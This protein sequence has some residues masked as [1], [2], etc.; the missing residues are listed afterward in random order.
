[1][2]EAF[3]TAIVERL[4]AFDVPLEA[5][6]VWRPE[7]KRFGVVLAPAIDRVGE[8]WRLGA[9]LIDREAHLF[10]T[11]KV[12]RAVVPKDFNSDKSLAGQERREI[13]RAASRGRFRPGVSVNYEWQPLTLDEA[14][15]LAQ[16]VTLER[17][18][19]ERIELL[20]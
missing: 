7:K 4:E 8:A 5:L 19:E 15:E 20:D 6:G 10:A 3:L 14:R 13:Q 18:L 16:P 11:G 2:S 17:Y 1:M 12:T 9:L